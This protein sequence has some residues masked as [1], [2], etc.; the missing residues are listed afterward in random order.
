MRL[1]FVVKHNID[2]F[3]FSQSY[4][5]FYDK[6]EKSN[7]FLDAIIKTRDEDVGSRTLHWLNEEL[8]SDGINQ[9]N[10]CTHPSSAMMIKSIFFFLL[11]FFFF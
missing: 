11:Y 8:I 10:V 7:F 6:L 2:D 9:S 3:E 4:L 5:F 1:P